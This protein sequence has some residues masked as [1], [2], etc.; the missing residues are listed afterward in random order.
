MPADPGERYMAFAW[1]N[2]DGLIL[3]F[4]DG[5][6]DEGIRVSGTGEDQSVSRAP[7][8]SVEPHPLAVRRHERPRPCLG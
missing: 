4:G 2:T 5:V 3:D 8:W 7:R 6:N 1:A